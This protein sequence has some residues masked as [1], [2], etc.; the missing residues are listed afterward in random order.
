MENKFQSNKQAQDVIFSQKIKR[1]ILPPLVFRNNIVPQANTQKRLGVT[2][3][4]KG[5]TQFVQ[6]V[7]Y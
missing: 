2:L 1:N 7:T 4:F 3:N 6:K 5:N